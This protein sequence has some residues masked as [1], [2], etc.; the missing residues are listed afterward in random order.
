MTSTAPPVTVTTHRPSYEGANIRTWIGFK[1]FM[2]I[3]EQAI[4]DWHRAHALGPHRLYHEHGLGLEIVDSSV[5]LPATLEVDD[6]VSATVTGTEPG[7]FTVTLH[8][9]R[10]GGRTLVLK[11]RVGVALV[12]ERDAPA[13]AALD[14]LPGARLLPAPV[15]RPGT[16]VPTLTAVPDEAGAFRWDWRVPYFYCHFSDRLQHSGYV[17]AL[18]D[19]VDRF[20]A[21]RGISVG[22]M[23]AERGWIPV[24]SRARVRMLAPVHL[25]E[26]VRTTF[27]VDDIL[28]R[29][30]FDGRMDSY[31]IRGSE[32]V[33]TATARILHGYAISRGPH[34]GEVAELDDEVVTAL[35]GADG[36]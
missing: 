32:V 8:V 3:V 15:D 25:E 22:R 19:V 16:P 17:R 11:G 24:V 30:M 10:D 4:L 36:R 35:R 26:T 9:T 20:L 34:A 28:R 12:R 33:R 7:R 13:A 1:H 5:Q 21:A 29:S 14:G 2:Y 27:V 6:D 31:V 23:L 18:E